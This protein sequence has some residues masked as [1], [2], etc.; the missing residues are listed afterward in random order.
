VGAAITPDDRFYVTALSG[1]Q[2]VVSLDL[3]DPLRP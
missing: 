1:K 3:A 2:Q